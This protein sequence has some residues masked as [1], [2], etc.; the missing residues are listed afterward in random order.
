MQHIVT[1]FVIKVLAFAYL[2]FAWKYE[3]FFFSKFKK[4]CRDRVSK[5]RLSDKFI[6]ET[7]ATPKPKR[8][9]P[10]PIQR[11]ADEEDSSSQPQ[12]MPPKKAITIP[13][14]ITRAWIE[15]SARVG[16]KIHGIKAKKINKHKP[17]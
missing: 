12:I 11:Y 8:E 13:P 1:K 5:I 16:L 7:N 2:I 15:W 6:K 10:I 17:Q 3:L 9:N 14:Y 4:T